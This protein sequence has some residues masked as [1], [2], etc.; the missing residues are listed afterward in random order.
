MLDTLLDKA[1]AILYALTA[2]GLVLW[3][4]ILWDERNRR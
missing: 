1:I 3:A 2:T 4:W